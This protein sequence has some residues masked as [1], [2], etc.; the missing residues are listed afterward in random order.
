MKTNY[1]DII[2]IIDTLAIIQGV[3]FGLFFIY[4][5]KKN[6]PHLFFGL[7]ILTYSLELI[8]GLIENLNFLKIYPRLEYLPLNFYYFTLPL[9]YIYVNKVSIFSIKINYKVLILGILE[10]LIGLLLILIYTHKDLFNIIEYVWLLFMMFFIP[11]NI[12]MSILIIRLVNKHTKQ[13]MCQYSNN[14]KLKLRWCK[15]IA[16]VLLTFLIVQL[17]LIVP[18]VM[19]K[20]IHIIDLAV[21]IVNMIVIYW[22]SI[23]GL[24]QTTILSLIDNEDIQNNYE[25]Q[26]KKNNTT[27]TEEIETDFELIVA[28]ISQKELYKK[29]DLTILDISNELSIH[30]KRISRAINLMANQNF[31]TYINSFRVEKAKKMLTDSNY[32]YLSIEGIGKESGFNAKSAFYKAF[33]E[34]LNITPGQYR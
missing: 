29:V 8:P 9:F 19:Q 12:Y 11:Y 34:V 25:L 18:I 10:I 2:I 22:M 16:L 27:I 4:K 32:D 13:V 31:S 23:K 6:P 26:E 17:I 20:H 15:H 14:D 21:T 28:I 7:F 30:S 3:L 5:S 33:K 1:Q 24:E